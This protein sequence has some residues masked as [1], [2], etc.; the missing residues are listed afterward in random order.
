[1]LIEVVKPRDATNKEKGDILEKLA[2]NFLKRQRYQVSK[3]VRITA[4]ELDLLCKH[5]VSEKTVYVECKAHKDPLSVNVL[6]NLLGTI[7]LQEYSEGWLISTGPLGKDAK[8]FM[9]TWGRKKSKEKEKL[10]I[11]TPDRILTSLLMCVPFEIKNFSELSAR[12]AVL[13]RTER[14]ITKILGIKGNAL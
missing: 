1:M 6:K 12:E 8:G 10:S 2:E 3:Q 13:S 4:S 9:E 11:Y 14:A 7:E 5:K